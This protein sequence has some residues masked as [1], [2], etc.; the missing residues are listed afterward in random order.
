MQTIYITDIRRIAP[1]FDSY[2]ALLRPER[3]EKMLGY[4]FLKDRL[5]CLTGGLLM[6]EVTGGREIH[7]TG[8]G[9]PF[10]PEGPHI[11]LSHS[12]DFVCLAVCASAPVGIDIEHQRDQDFIAL[13]KT[14]FH[15]IEYDF[16][17]QEPRAVRFY[18]LWTQKESYVKMIG[19]GLSI[20][21]ASFCVLPGKLVLPRSGVPYIQNLDIMKGYS[22]AVCAGEPIE[23]QIIEMPIPPGSL[24]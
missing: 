6:E 18:D 10:L 13:G 16:F 11:S 21:P 17:M 1:F 14:A 19:S 9:K 5:R 7:Y 2:A 3:R 15:P 4:N 23:A 20:E 24:H 8:N 22:M 12:G